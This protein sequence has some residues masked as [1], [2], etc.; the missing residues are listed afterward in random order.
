MKVITSIYLN[1]RPELR[2]EWLAGTD[3][4]TELEDALVSQIFTLTAWL[5]LTCQP[6]EYALRALVQFYNKRTYPGTIPTVISPE[7]QHRRTEST[8]AV[9]LED[10][11]LHNHNRHT[12]SADSDVFPPRSSTDLPYNPDLMIEFWLHEYEDIMNEV[13]GETEEDGI[14]IARVGMAERDDPAWN[15]LDEIMRNGTGRG[16]ED[17]EISDS[18]SVVSVGELGAEARVGVG[19]DSD[20]TLDEGRHE[21]ELARQQRRQSGNE[22]TWE[23]MSPKTLSLLPR[24]PAERR[25]S[26]SSSDRGSPLRAITLGSGSGRPGGDMPVFEDEELDIPGPMPIMRETDD[27]GEGEGEFGAVDEVEYAYGE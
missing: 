27:D 26:S 3:Q 6:Q 22:N 17:D 4:D 10:P 19:I 18:E 15:R 5:N 13:F 16:M 21:R 24:S 8:S 2:D 14:G 23:H 1:C 9:M 20:L 7:P 11:A 25:R 12:S